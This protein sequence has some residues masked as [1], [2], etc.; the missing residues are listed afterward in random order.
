MSGVLGRSGRRPTDIVGKRFGRLVA[1]RQGEKRG[2]RTVWICRCDCGTESHVSIGNLN[3]GST[4]SC[5]CLRREMHTSHGLTDTPTYRSWQAM[6]SRCTRPSTGA[7]QQYGAKGVTVCQRWHKFDNF[8]A[9]MGVRP[10]GTSIDRIDNERGYE[11]SNCR[12]STR[13][14]QNK[15][16]RPWKKKNKK[17]DSL[18]ISRRI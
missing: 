9:D 12:W 14:E 16:R 10:E 5:G 6:I 4:Q 13:S 1:V 11:L 7:F 8:L 15:N 17:L 3:N 18:G 2:R